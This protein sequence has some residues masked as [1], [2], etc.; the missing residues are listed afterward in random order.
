MQ[1]GDSFDR[2]VARASRLRLS[3]RLLG[4]LAFV[5]AG[6]W[7]VGAFGPPPN[8]GKVWAGYASILVFGL[9]AIM[10]ARRLIEGGDQIVVD[11]QG[12]LWTQWSDRIIPWSAIRHIDRKSVKRQHF[13]CLELVDPARYPPTS[14]LGRFAGSNRLLGF[15]DIAI[16]VGGTDRSFDELVD[17]VERFKRGQ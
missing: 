6:L 2:F 12:I 14:L 13:L 8:P 17:A 15:G 11:H 10:G 9:V 7:M 5:A 1:A 16:N 4:C 3:G